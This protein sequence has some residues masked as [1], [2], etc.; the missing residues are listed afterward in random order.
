MN[1]AWLNRV[2]LLKKSKA[3]EASIHLRAMSIFAAVQG[4]QLV[5][6]GRNDI[7]AYENIIG[8][9]RTVGFIP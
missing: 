6:R 5:A 9:Y 1:I 2:L 8:M 7:T 3:T 4:A